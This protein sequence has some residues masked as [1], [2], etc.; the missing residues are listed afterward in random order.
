MAEIRRLPPTGGIDQF[1][2]NTDAAA[3]P[4][5]LRAAVSA[6]LSPRLG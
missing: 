5:L 3:D 6:R 4:V 2:D 1:I